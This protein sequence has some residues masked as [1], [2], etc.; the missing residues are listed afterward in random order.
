MGLITTTVLWVLFIWLDVT[1]AWRLLLFLPAMISATGFLQ[2][3]MHFCAYFGL[4]NLFNFD[5]VGKT[6][7]IT[8]AEFH[9]K[10]RRKA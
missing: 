6:D 10:D 9:A 4:A 5:D 8:Q 7:T 1:P 3:Y 2:S